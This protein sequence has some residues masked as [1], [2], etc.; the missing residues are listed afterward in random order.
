MPKFTH[1]RSYGPGILLCLTVAAAAQFLAQHYG[2]PQMLFALLLGMAFHFVTEEGQGKCVQGVEFTAKKVLRFGVALLGL[3]LTFGEMISLGWEAVALVTGGVILT[4]C[5][6]ILGARLLG[7]RIRFGTLT[8]GAVAI[9]GASA[10]LAIAAV[11]PKNEFSER[12][13]IFTVIAVTA[14]ST[15]AMIVYPIIASFAGLDDRT[16]GIFRKS[17]V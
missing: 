9:C 11:L 16:A 14:F 17:V 3:R 5:F 2:A 6:G 12:N 4:I 10:A 8:G 15:I 7:R 1:A 13:L